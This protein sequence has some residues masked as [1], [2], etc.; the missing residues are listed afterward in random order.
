MMILLLLLAEI[1]VSSETTK[2]FGEDHKA[3]A[4]IITN[5]YEGTTVP[6]IGIKKDRDELLQTFDRPPH[7]HYIRVDNALEEDMVDAL[8]KAAEK[9]RSCSYRCLVIAFSGHGGKHDGD[10]VIITEDL[11]KIPVK[12]F[13]DF[14]NATF[15]GIDIPKAFLIDAC[16]GR[17][18]LPIRKSITEQ[19]DSY[20]IAS[21]T[22]FGHIAAMRVPKEEGSYWMP[23]VARFIRER[24]M[25]II[26]VI[27]AANKEVENDESLQYRQTPQLVDECFSSTLNIYAGMSIT[28]CI[29]KIVQ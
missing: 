28:I 23:V 26:D 29:S 3:L 18:A 12:S 7:F 10:S 6:L 4:V 17:A 9:A 25:P 21:A 8:K 11:R 13:V 14:V 27:R 15:S 16:R 22:K 5:T 20:L 24:N 1:I 19:D 2:G